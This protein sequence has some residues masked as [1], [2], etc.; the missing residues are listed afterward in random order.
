MQ[1]LLSIF[2]KTLLNAGDVKQYGTF[3]WV[4][5]C[6]FFSYLPQHERKQKKKI[7]KFCNRAVFILW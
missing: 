5:Q 4:P 6:R 3:C 7:F 2:S 1:F